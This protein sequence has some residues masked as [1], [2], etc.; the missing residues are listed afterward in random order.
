MP[1]V[2]GIVL[3]ASVAVFARY[4]GFGRDRD[5]RQLTFPDA[6][7]DAVVIHL[8]LAGRLFGY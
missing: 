1:F 2:I 7:F 4:V 3:S 8:I 5:A 6:S